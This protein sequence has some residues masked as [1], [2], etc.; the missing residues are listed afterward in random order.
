MTR[1]RMIRSA[2]LVYL[3]TAASICARAQN[4]PAWPVNDPAKMR[5]LLQEW[6][7]QTDRINTLDVHQKSF[8]MG[9]LH[10]QKQFLLPTRITLISS[11]GSS[12]RE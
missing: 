1:S 12:S 7:R 10:L 6:E 4:A 3:V 8:K 11:D 2:T 5:W 9:W